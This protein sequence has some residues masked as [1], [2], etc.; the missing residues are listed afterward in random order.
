MA[1]SLNSKLTPL[2]LT[3]PPGPQS[4]LHSCDPRSEPILNARSIFPFVY[5]ISPWMFHYCLKNKMPQMELTNLLPTFVCSILFEGNP[6]HSAMMEGNWAVAFDS[7]LFFSLP[8]ATQSLNLSVLITGCLMA[9]LL[10][11]ISTD[12]PGRHR[13]SPALL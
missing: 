1:S 2:A 11:S 10:L 9:H 4:H 8:S 6:V 5:N 12:S 3:Y 7:T 13:P